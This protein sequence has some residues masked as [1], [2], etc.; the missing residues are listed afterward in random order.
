MSTIRK[1]LDVHDWST[2]VTIRAALP[3]DA[4]ALRRLA[5]LDEEPPIVGDALLAEVGGELWAAAGIDETAVIADPFRPSGEL[6][7]LLAE[8]AGRIRRAR[9][10]VTR[11]RRAG[12]PV[13]QA[14]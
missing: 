2:G 6:A 5:A 11:I 8:R 12:R 14:A 4:E 1:R 7:L 9:R 13:R 3:A 10:Q